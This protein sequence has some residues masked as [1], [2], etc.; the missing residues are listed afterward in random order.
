[1]IRVLHIF[2]EMANGGVEHFVMDYY[3][4]I[5]RDEV[6]FDFLV[7]VDKKGAFED[8]IQSL[9]GIVHHAYSFKRNPVRNYK[10]IARIVRENN[11]HIVHRHTGS[12]FGYFDLRAAKCGGADHLIIHS[13]NNRAGNNALHFCAKAFLS[14]DCE[15]LA[16]SEEAGKWL[17]GPNRSFMII[18]NAIDCEKFQYSEDIRDEIRNSLGLNDKFVIGHIG[19]FEEQKN[20][21][22]LIDVFNA[23]LKKKSNSVLLCVGT[24]SMLDMVEYKARQL[25]IAD[26]VMFLGNRDDVEKLVNVFDIFVLPSKYEGF[27]ITLLE[28]QANGLKCYTSK[29]VVPKAV[30]VTN[31]IEYISLDESAEYW[32]ECILGNNNVRDISAFEK[33]AS[34]GYD[35]HQKAIELCDY[36]QR[37][38]WDEGKQ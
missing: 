17:F 24:G 26:K 18:N 4:H 33:V 1:M 8:E 38:L 27:G 25:Q 36:Y 15:R 7:S 10:D 28:A 5:N 22:F 23:V 37:L 35:I 16:C 31:S 13:H 6:Q 21:L 2:H 12:A 32:S 3:R 9:G 14:I 20:Q 29:N 30:N 11:Y 19:R 34:S